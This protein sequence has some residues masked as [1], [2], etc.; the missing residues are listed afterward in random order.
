MSGPIPQ[1]LFSRF[2]AGMFDEAATIGVTTAGQAFFGN[3]AAS[4]SRTIHSPDHNTVDID[5]IR[6]NEKTAALIP[7]GMVAHTL[8]SLQKNSRTALHTGFSR[9]YPLA[10]ET[11]DITA[12]NLLV[13]VPGEP[14][15]NSPMTQMMRYRYHLARLHNENIRK[16]I[17]LDERLAW[18]SLMTGKQDAILGT[19]NTDLQYDFRRN[20]NLTI[21]CGVSWAGGAANILADV[22]NACTKGRQIGHTSL[23]MMIL[24]S[25]AMGSFV[26]DATVQKVADNRRF[27][28][29]SLGNGAVM[30]AKYQRFVDCGMVFQGTLRTPLGYE[31]NLF[32]YPEFYD[33]DAGVSTPYLAADKV[34]L[35]SSTARCD[36]Y[37]GPPEQLPMIPQRAELYRQM[38]GF[39]PSAC[40]MPPKIKAAGGV[41]AP[42]AF[43][44]SGYVSAD[45][46][47]TTI[48]T[49]H[50]PIF[51]T[52]Q[53]DAFV[54]LDTEP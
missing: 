18:Q 32:T 21:Q 19:S 15:V 22:D 24:G 47:T 45:W 16:I 7:R 48:E 52:V 10:S 36:R 49:Q 25:G 38:F 14:A 39:D 13:R 44:C 30:P 6:G 37:F 2:A 31:L 34:L 40:P 27:T 5:I 53:T 11:G 9:S 20:G 23:D 50:A 3:P 41:I 29:I 12:G 42:E 43:Y 8:G 4:G 51:A 54:V 1:D 46:K 26:R 33:T 28:F 35:C 17:R